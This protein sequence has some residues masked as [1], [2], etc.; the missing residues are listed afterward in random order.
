MEDLCSA[1][2]VVTFSEDTIYEIIR[3]KKPFAAIVNKDDLYGGYLDGICCT[4][5]EIEE[6]FNQLFSN[7]NRGD[8]NKYLY[9][10]GE[11]DPDLIKEKFEKVI[12]DLITQNDKN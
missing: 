7:D 1:K 9:A 8:I 10:F 2:K 3:A 11:T 5:D 4:T 12:L 6:C